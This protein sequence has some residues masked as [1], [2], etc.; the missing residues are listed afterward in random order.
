MLRTKIGLEGSIFSLNGLVRVEFHARQMV[1]EIQA[2]AKIN[3]SQV[4]NNQRQRRMSVGRLAESSVFI[5][6]YS[7][8]DVVR[9]DTVACIVEGEARKCGRVEFERDRGD[10]KPIQG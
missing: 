1:N 4:L 3:K 6:S 9:G 8:E 5:V 7:P 2:D 10:G